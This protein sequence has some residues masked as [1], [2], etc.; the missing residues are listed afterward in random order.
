LDRWIH[1]DV[2]VVLNKPG[3]PDGAVRLWVDGSLILDAPG[4]V[5]RGDDKTSLIGVLAGAGYRRLPEAP[6]L[7]RISPLDIAW[8]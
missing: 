2:E 7:L 5:L 3:E 1:L 4:I 6:G 8:K